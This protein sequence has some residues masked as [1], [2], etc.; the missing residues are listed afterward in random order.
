MNDPSHPARRL[1][2]FLARPHDERCLR[3]V[4]EFAVR[5]GVSFVHTLRARGRALPL[6]LFPIE[7]AV[8]D[9]SAFCLTPL[10]SP[11][12]LGE[13]LEL[14]KALTA[15]RDATD[16]EL[17]DRFETVLRRHLRQGIMHL[18]HEKDPLGYN[19]RRSLLRLLH[20]GRGEFSRVLVRGRE[21]WRWTKAE[22]P[23]RIELPS[24][25]PAL[26]RHWCLAA[27]SQSG[28]IP[29]ICRV[30]FDKLDSDDRFRNSLGFFAI[31]RALHDPRTD[32]ADIE[33]SHSQTPHACLDEQRVRDTVLAAV[34]ATIAR[35]LDRLAKTAGL[36]PA[37][38]QTVVGAVML[39][40]NDWAEHKECDSRRLYLE[41]LTGPLDDATYRQKYHYLWNTLVTN[42]LNH[43]RRSL[44]DGLST[45]D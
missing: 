45:E 39:L 28:N 30:L 22:H 37:E 10:F 13:P 7:N 19:T 20:H 40:A 18:V 38:R 14:T 4:Y 1:R 16:S 32:E 42:T 41:E 23:H 33:P 3:A 9:L 2:E 17:L 6:D 25:E 26:L 43:V 12:R 8:P 29:G 24:A 36:T 27:Q 11:A 21:E 35:D 15:Y 44:S 34:S 5:R 31:L